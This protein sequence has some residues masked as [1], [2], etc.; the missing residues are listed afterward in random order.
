MY[1]RIIM[2]GLVLLLLPGWAQALDHYSNV[3]QDQN[4]RAVSGATITVYQAGTTL[5][6][7]LYA[8]NGTT[9]KANPFTTAIDG[10]Y[11]FYAADGRY[12]ITIRKTGYTSIY[13]DP[14]KMQGLGLFDPQQHIIPYGN[15][16]P[17]SPVVGSTYI[18][19]E[20]FST[21]TEGSGA[22]ATL[23]RWSG[24]SW[25]VLTGAGGGGWPSDTS[26]KSITTAT[27]AANKICILNNTGDGTCFWTDPTSGPQ[28]QQVCSGVLN[29]CNYS[30]QLAA[31]KYKEITNASG[32]SIW[33]V[34]ESTGA[35]TNTTLDATATGNTITLLDERHF[36]VATCQNATASANF[37]I[38]TTNAPTATCDTGT[39]T[40]K[41]YLA[42]NDTTDQ[43][44]QDHI[45]LPVGFVS[46]DAHLRWKAA[47]TT[48]AVGWCVQLIR[49]PDGATSDPAYPAQAAGN[50][51]SDT[52]KGTTLQEN[53]ATIPG[54]TCTSC[55][56][57]DHVYVRV[58]RDA[59]GSAVTDSMTGDGLLL[60]YGKTIKVAH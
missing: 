41:A 52:A 54:V 2:I 28:I 55:V 15:A 25:D 17:T 40:Q 9:L 3:A 24:I 23:C 32:T 38:P 47:A 18:L 35:M 59:G 44:F 42:F 4:G 29:G 31:G 50:C 46:M 60:T 48:G 6:A 7:T 34:T 21:C 10:M 39:N 51:V 1:A 26:S 14:V 49:V 57:G 36:P 27:G 5:L 53:A 16:L 11:D 20:S 22:N 8:D 12:D 45:I 13:W 56:A 30:Q 33:R 43:S 19:T 58:S 37:D